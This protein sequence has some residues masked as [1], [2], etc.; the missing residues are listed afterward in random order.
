MK[1]AFLLGGLNRGG[2]ETIMLD[3]FRNWK[4]APFE[5]VGLHRKDGSMHEAFYAAGPKLYHVAPQLF[6]YF[7]YIL[8]LRRILKSENIA[9]V[10]AQHW[11]DGI[12]AWMAT[13]GMHIRLVTTLH[14]FYPMKGVNGILCRM[15]I[16]LADDMCFVSRYEQV[17]YQNQMHIS[18]IKCHVIYNGVDF[19]KIDEACLCKDIYLRRPS[20]AMVGSF[21]SGRVHS[22]IIKALLLLNQQGI[23][24]F[25]FYFIGRRS[26]M[27]P[28]I[29]DECVRIC[30][31]NHLTNVHFLGGRDDV[32]SI[33]K[34]INGFVYSTNH[35]TFGIAVVE[36]MAC[37]LPIVVNDWSVMKEVCG[38][39]EENYVQYFKSKNAESC[40][41]AI[42]QL[43]KDIS[44]SSAEFQ[45]RC[46]HNAQWAR[47]RY[48]LDT[49]IA[50]LS[51]IYT[52]E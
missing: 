45:S 3:V 1:I 13:I 46:A 9:I 32:P 36:A 33:L 44:A 50:T 23:N 7:R 38:E 41:E 37:G 49:Y 48:A 29:F 40:A 28:Q 15:S 51:H 12:Y 14:G 39:S 25:D 16:R 19:T 22:V 11:L 20:F 47:E 2:A 21:T 35:D 10:H 34:S 8:H 52:K 6:G 17:W 5:F 43:L 27:E 31:Q 26:N 42:Q 30:E 18:D 4:N 24:D